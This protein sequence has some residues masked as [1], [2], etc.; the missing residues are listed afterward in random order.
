MLLLALTVMPLTAHRPFAHRPFAHRP[1]AHRASAQAVPETDFPKAS[2]TL[3]ESL[4]SVRALHEL[5]D[6]RVLIID[7]GAH[8]VVAADFASGKV[9]ERMNEGSGDDEYRSL[10][11]LWSWPGDSIASFDGLKGQLVIFDPDGKRARVLGLGGG[12]APGAGM[13]EAG[14]GRGGVMMDPSAAGRGGMGRA[15]RSIDFRALVGTD[16]LVGAGPSARS[17][18]SSPPSAP[19]PRM[20]YPLLR[21]S[22]RRPRPDTIAQLMPPQAPRAPLTNSVGSFVVYVGTAPLQQVDAWAVLRDG[23]VAVVRSASYRIDWFAPDGTRSQTD[24]IPFTPVPVTSSDKKRIVE[25]YKPVGE[26]ALAALPTRTSILAMTF[27][28]PLAWPAMHPPFRG[29]MAPL[30]DARDRIWLATRC[31]T[32]DQA[33]CYDVIGRDGVRA[34][35]FRMPP[36]TIV[37]G[38]GR[39][40]VYTAIVQKSD[41]SILQRHVL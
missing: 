13:G 5:R 24:S 35:R 38:F 22:L 12:G 26:A 40:V 30:V 33:M 19:P 34:Q 25:E 36:R 3:K 17:T 1:F 41:K 23:T 10:T 2:A 16:M 14:G 39:D 32:D 31:A 29:D 27:E 11:Q 28:E 6:G 37:V 18:Q 7:A 21:L 4:K 15:P 20:P 9:T 8:K